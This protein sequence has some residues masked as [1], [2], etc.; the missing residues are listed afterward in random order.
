M[1]ASGASCMFQTA[2]RTAETA[3]S[4]AI[5]YFRL[6]KDLTH[7]EIS[8][9]TVSMLPKADRRAESADVPEKTEKI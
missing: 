5:L 6:T 2:V 4:A 8:A 9:T 1:S 3:E 7:L